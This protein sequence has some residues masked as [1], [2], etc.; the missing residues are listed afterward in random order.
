MYWF[1][2]IQA[3]MKVNCEDRKKEKLQEITKKKRQAV[4][5]QAA[6]A[7]PKIMPQNF[8]ID[9]KSAARYDWK[10]FK[11]QLTTKEIGQRAKVFLDNETNAAPT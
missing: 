4:K 3:I 10:K 9:C 5:K 8:K 1:V 7:E 6:G 11:Q 2:M